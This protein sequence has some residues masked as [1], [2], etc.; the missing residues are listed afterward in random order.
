MNGRGLDF[1]LSLVGLVTMASLVGRLVCLKTFE[2]R[3]K[4]CQVT[5]K[6]WFS[7]RWGRILQHILCSTTPVSE[8]I[9]RRL[10]WWSTKSIP[11]SAQRCRRIGRIPGIDN[12]SDGNENEHVV[13]N[14]DDHRNSPPINEYPD[15]DNNEN[16]YM[17]GVSCITDWALHQWPT[18][19]E[20]R[21]KSQHKFRSWDPSNPRVLK[22]LQKDY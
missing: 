2:P 21:T 6:S 14:H 12:N 19:F 9:G 7:R 11:S 18:T 15:D 5:G 20:N 10:G 3:C 4:R 1:D 16:N 13:V 22:T 17:K 8:P